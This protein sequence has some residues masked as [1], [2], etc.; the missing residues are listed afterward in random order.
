[1]SEKRMA[2][3]Y[4]IIR[5]VT[6]GDTEVVLGFDP[7]DVDGQN[8]MTALCER[9]AILMRYEQ[10]LASDSYPEILGIFGNRIAEQAKQ[11]EAQLK[12]ENMDALDNR[13]FD[14]N[15]CSN[16]YGCRLISHEDDLNGQVVIIRPEVLKYEYQRATRQLMLCT[17]GF[18]A[19]PHSRGSACYCTNLYTG[20]SG[21]FERRDILAI[22]NPQMVPKW[23]MDGL[24]KAKQHEET[25]PNRR[26]EATR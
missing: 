23:A 7:N 10:V 8:Y 22:M 6:V 2:G 25:K 18:G 21:R 13:P 14:K 11:L 1:M 12:Q 17:G 4:E 19:S 3:D 20:D 5:A 26:I 16:M 24:E 9:N 15:R